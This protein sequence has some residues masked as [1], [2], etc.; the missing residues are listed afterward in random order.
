MSEREKDLD[1]PLAE[2]RAFLAEL[3]KKKAARA[4]RAP[5]SFAQQRLWLLHQ[6]DPA[7]ASYNISRA[8]RLRGQLD[9]QALQNSLNA[10]VTRHASLRTNFV[11]FDGEPKQV[12]SATRAI[13]LQ[14]IDLSHLPLIERELEAGKMATEAAGQGFNLERQEL[15]RASLL[16]LDDQDH[17]LVLTMHH[18]VSDG[19]S[20]GILFRELSAV[21]D[22]LSRSQPSPLARL[23]IQYADF[24][25]WQREWLQG[26]ELEKQLRYWKEQLAGAP[27]MLE[28][29]TDRPRPSLQTFAGA[30]HTITLG[31]ELTQS[32]NEFSRRENVTL[33]MS[34]LSAFQTFLYR[35]TNQ[36]DI[37]VGTPIANRTRT[38]TEGLIGFFVN[39]LVMRTDLSGNPAF[40]E[41]LSRVREVALDAFAHQDLPFEKLVEEL[42]PERSLSHMPVFQV[43]FA[44]QNAP[45]STLSLG[46]LELT[47]FPFEK[48]TAK[49]D[50]SLYV[51]ETTSGLTLTFEYN[52]DLFDALTVERMASHFETLLKGIA[53]NPQQRIA[54]LPLLDDQ[55]K[56]QILVEWNDLRGES[57]KNQT[58]EFGDLHGPDARATHQIF[59][60]QVERSPLASAVTF[61]SESVSYSELNRRANQLAHFLVKLGHPPESRFGILLERSVEMVVAMLAILK[62]GGAY[63]P[64]DPAYPDDRL[65]F[66]IQDAGLSSVLS[67][68]NLSAKCGPSATVICLDSKRSDIERQDEGNPNT[69]IIAENLAYVIY[70]S[71]STG[72]PK[73]VAVTHQALVHLSAS[74]LRHVEFRPTDVWTVVHSIAFDFSVWEI[75]PNLLHGG[76]LVVVPREVTQSPAELYDLIK[77][78]HVTVLNQTPAALRQLLEVRRES[79]QTQPDW[80]VRLIVCGGDALDHE[81]AA[82]LTE[83]PVPVWNFYGPTESTVWATANLLTQISGPNEKEQA[84]DCSTLNSIGRP[85]PDIQ[86]YLLNERFQ[87]APVGVPAELFI[88]GQGLA[89]GYLNRADLTA[90]RFVPDPF[91]N[92][93]GSRLYRTGDLARYRR[94]GQIEFLGRL[95]HQIKLRGF[96]IELGEIEATIGRHP[97]VAA[98]V[99]VIRNDQQGDKRLIAFVV[100]D[101]DRIPNFNDLRASL[102]LFLPDYMIPSSFVMLEAL[103]LTSNGKVD[104]TALSILDFSAANLEDKF[105]APRTPREEI[106][107]NIWTTVLGL[108]R[109]GVNDNF[110]SLGGHSLLATQVVSRLR[111]ALSLDVPLRSLF[112]HPTVA[113][114]TAHL[115]ESS[116]NGVP[117]PL[118]PVS[119]GP[120]TP[121]SF[122]QQRLWFLNQ[123]E[124]GSTYNMSRA[125][126]LKGH[127]EVTA[128]RQALN[129]LVAR[130]ESLRT[131]FGSIDG[132]PLQIVSAEREVE[133]TLTDLRNFSAEA[134]EDEARRLAAEIS[135]REF[136]L[137]E[138]QLLRAR[139]FQL[140]DDEHILLLVT[141]HI[142]SD[143]WSMGI[144]LRETGALY[145]SFASGL[146]SALPALP[147][148]Y[149]DFALWQ[150]EW[151]SSGALQERIDYWKKQ[152]YGAPALLKLPTDRIRPLVQTSNGS[153]YSTLLPTKVSDSLRE[154]SRR[155]GVTLFM[156]LLAAFQTLLLRYTQQEDLVVGTPIANRNQSETEGLIGYFANTL[157]LRSDLSGNPTFRELL[158]RV[159]EVSLEAYAH[160]E[161]P[162]EKLVEELQPQRS[163]SH[164]PLVQVL[165]ALQNVPKTN[166]VMPSLDVSEFSFDRHTSKLDLSLYTRETDEGLSNWFEYSTDLFEAATIERMAG[167]FEIL[168]N[169]IVTDPDQ[170]LAELPLLTAPEQA[171][172]LT[173]LN[174]TSQAFP[175]GES[176][177]ELFERQVAQHPEAIAVI[178]EDRRLSYEELNRK[179]NRIAHDLRLSGIGP[180]ELVGVFLDRSVDMIAALLG[181]MKAGAAYVPIDTSYPAERVSFILRDAR[182]KTLLTKHEPGNRLPETDASLIFVEDYQISAQ[183]NEA[184]PNSAVTSGNLAYVIYTSGSTGKPKG[185]AVNHSSV[186]NLFRATSRIFG[187]NESDAWTVTHSYSFDFSVWEIFGALLSGGKLVIVPLRVAQSPDEF[188]QLLASEQVTV[189]GLTPSALRQL[190]PLQRNNGPVLSLRLIVCGGEAF[191]ADMLADLMEWNVPVWNFFGP[192]EATVWASIRQ[193][194]AGDEKH[195]I[196]PL[197]GPIANTQIHILD[198]YDALVPVGVP[199]E[200]CIGG[201]PLARG[202][203]NRPELTAEKFLPDPFSKRPGARLYHTGDVARHLPDG[204]IEY[205]GRSDHQVK[206]RGFRIELG[207]IE[208]VLS[209]HPGVQQSVI[210]CREDVPGEQTLVA[211][212]VGDVNGD[213]DPT[214]TELRAFVK[215]E[216]PEY[217][218]PSDFVTMPSLPINASGKIDRLALPAPSQIR[219]ELGV[220]FISPR[221]VLERELAEI[222][223]GVLRRENVGIGDN[224]FDLG[225]HSLLATQ[226]VS[227]IRSRLNVELPLRQLFETPTIEGLARSIGARVVAAPLQGRTITKRNRRNAEKLKLS[228]EQLSEAEVD[229]L[230]TNIIPRTDR[231]NG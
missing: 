3:L 134:R 143:G 219:P 156:T 72:E 19:W 11:V 67:S 37:L 15:L 151:L 227:R 142:V 92:T 41:L 114:L 140:S 195:Q 202:Y 8:V 86:V 116:T 50:L 198:N 138:D 17:V 214:V 6:L 126:R 193:V 189:L 171:R 186:V 4:T 88:G 135:L 149:A 228:V 216:L 59:E 9:Q 129:A 64:L 225:G 1:Q 43:L 191:P 145:E 25:R 56:Q 71:G 55:E 102:Q 141:H 113:G 183:Q 45:R 107:A 35:Y 111:H 144:M 28:F 39:T 166:L 213:S 185:V 168:L 184:N 136:D 108:E 110:F 57:A 73:G 40:R 70:T 197:G 75:W 60:A 32:L 79:L 23:P 174:N 118:T 154:L 95:D 215:R 208:A 199:G 106:V 211:Y 224:F 230:L 165:F 117:P 163:L 38:E 132:E 122:A 2:K 44:L 69:N 223:T 68:E 146:H 12:I 148:Q 200:L 65:Q 78:E 81:L 48:K 62:A 218:C 94:N 181:I 85:L 139:L 172:L 5:L 103:P 27:A 194:G 123:L 131:N 119:R 26:D 207:E 31:K 100:P 20:M 203:L 205:I 152:L 190:L 104:R 204:T 222:W 167:H 109:V 49:L 157:V 54:D 229:S 127:L 158:K 226:L 22:S 162:F 180:E 47:E 120:A 231:G 124:P 115:A 150:S 30:Y 83:L 182:I 210:L 63:V 170:R 212:I 220:R 177:P 36:Q 133:I 99:V 221:T 137:D 153:H 96:R 74:T 91:G 161:L 10:I 46:A 58:V 13:E 169:A 192:T 34:L 52:T 18:I 61:D 87:P 201:R 159:R 176:I 101:G 24:S 98:A 217:M 128:L 90:E 84:E 80:P 21:Y 147:L 130:H 175:E 160:Q 187:F 179:A 82:E 112:Q 155:E 76:R 105:V 188:Y 178:C 173:E 97:D 206:L 29:S 66:M 33:F 209:R 14:H 196:V 93:P 7:S 125:L 121:A 51:G 77:R 16:R 53:A 164:M 89:R 42:Q